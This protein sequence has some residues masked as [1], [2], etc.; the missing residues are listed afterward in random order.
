MNRVEGYIY[1]NVS[2]SNKGINLISIIRLVNV[3]F[4]NIITINTH[5]NKHKPD[6]LHFV[7]AKTCYSPSHIVL[8]ITRV[9][10]LWF[11][12]RVQNGPMVL[13]SINV[14]NIIFFKLYFIVRIKIMNIVRTTQHFLFNPRRRF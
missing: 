4:F 9:H 3:I 6:E 8:L 1:M 7:I 12:R 10:V 11:K 14:L 2:F 5:Y 13:L